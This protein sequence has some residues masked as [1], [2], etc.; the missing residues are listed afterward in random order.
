MLYSASQLAD[1]LDDPNVIVFDCRFRLEDP[2]WGPA[3]YAEG[4]IPGAQ[5]LNLDRDLAAP[6]GTHGGRHPLPDAAVLAAKLGH[7]G[8]GP[9]TTVVVYD[10]GEG[11]ATRAWWLIRYLGHDDVHVLDGGLQVWQAAGYA[12]SM[13]RP[14]P[15][16]QSLPLNVRHDWVVTAADV[17]QV[18]AGA[19]D[20]VL[21]DARARARFRGDVEPIDQVAGHIPTAHCAPWTEGVD[22]AGH[23]LDAAG[24][25][26]RF[27][28]VIESGKP[29]IAYCGS[30][31]TA[32]ANLFSLAIA[33]VQ[34]A[35]L[36]AGSW[37]DWITY[38]DAPVER[39]GERTR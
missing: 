31:V 32:C 12:L 20:A 14:T 24:Q 19:R 8:V 17:R 30:G 21:V 23:W 6:V 25:R 7:M 10:S 9:D 35:K 13:D 28:R 3:V 39:G 16:P 38:D 26:A 34:D 37:S 18:V 36:Y 5:Y 15:R 27:A 29:V 4:H 22:A 2:A 11:I 1:R 33:G